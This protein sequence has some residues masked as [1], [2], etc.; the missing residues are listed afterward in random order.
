[1]L[2]KTVPEI[3]VYVCYSSGLWC[4]KKHVLHTH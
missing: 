4:F 2:V 3:G 1:V